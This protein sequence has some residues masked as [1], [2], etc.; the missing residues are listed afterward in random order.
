VFEGSHIDLRKWFIAVYIFSSHKKGISS[1]QLA[2]GLGITQK[3]AWFM[4][5]RIKNA[6]QVKSLKVESDGLSQADE[7][8]VGSKNKNRHADKKVPESQGRSVKDKT[9]VLGLL[10]ADGT[11]SLSV[12]LDTKASTSK[13]VIERMIAGGAIVVTGEWLSY[14]GLS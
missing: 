7:T 11:V 13:P 4:L 3:G 5:G 9:P 2:R 6:F 14:K 8:F 10:K 12:V 1:H